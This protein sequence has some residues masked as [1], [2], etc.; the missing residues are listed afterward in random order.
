LKRLIPGRD[1]D[2]LKKGWSRYEKK[3]KLGEREMEF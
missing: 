1:Q 3:K 2:L